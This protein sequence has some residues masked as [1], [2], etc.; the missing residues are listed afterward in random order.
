MNNSELDIAFEKAFEKSSAFKGKVPQDV[1][2]KLYALYKIGLNETRLNSHQQQDT[3][4]GFKANAMFQFSQYTPDECKALY[5]ELV[6]DF[7]K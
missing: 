4:S 3:V 7:C 6:N 1:M 5:I 2:L